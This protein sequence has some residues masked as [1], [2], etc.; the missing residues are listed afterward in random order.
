MK[1]IESIHYVKKTKSYFVTLNDGSTM[2][3]E[4]DS[5]VKYN[6]YKGKELSEDILPQIMWHNEVAKGKEIAIKYLRFRRTSWEV[7]Q[8]LLQEKISKDV[9]PEILLSLTDLHL[10][11]DKSYIMDFVKDKMNLKKDGPM[12][13]KFAL[14][15]KGLHE[16]D[17]EEIH[18]Q[19]SEEQWCQLIEDLLEKKAETVDIQQQYK[20]IFTY[21]YGKGY[22]SHLIY[23]V[24]K[25]G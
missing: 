21:L 22:P 25:N 8:K 13:I 11:N 23:K 19:V 7:E 15:N 6:L 17:I 1:I 14:L 12:K 16:S 18:S 10:M 5:L 20:K 2:E 9:I 4:E 24:L 3:A